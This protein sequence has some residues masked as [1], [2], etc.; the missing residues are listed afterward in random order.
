MWMWGPQ[1]SENL[2][3]DFG[4]VDHEWANVEMRYFKQMILYQVEEL[5]FM[6]LYEDDQA[7]ETISSSSS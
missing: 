6:M 1:Q 7:Q 4:M 2:R 3:N 5:I